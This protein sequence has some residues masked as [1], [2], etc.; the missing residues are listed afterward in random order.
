MTW[1]VSLSR[2][3]PWCLISAFYDSSGQADFNF[4]KPYSEKTAELID[5]EVNLMIEKEYVRAKKILGENIDGLNRLAN[6]LLEKEVIFSEDLE[7]I[8]G[9]RPWEKKE[10]VAKKTEPKKRTTPAR[11]KNE[12]DQVEEKAEEAGPKLGEK[13]QKEETPRSKTA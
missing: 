6:Q 10:L 13:K 4:S 11:R 12:K 2:P 3:M 9:P 5:E 8:F 7:K 1:N